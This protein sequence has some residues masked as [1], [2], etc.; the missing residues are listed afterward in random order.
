MQEDLSWKSASGLNLYGSVWRPEKK[1]KAVICLVHG[2]GEHCLRYESYI[3][4]FTKKQIAFV[5]YDQMGHGAS[6]GKRGAISSYNDLLSDVQLCLDKA[7][8]I[9]PD[10]PKFL[11]GHSMGGNIALNFLLK[12]QPEINGA[13][14]TSPWLTLTNNPSFVLRALVSFLKNIFPNLTVN[15]GLEI[16]YISTL[17]DEVEKYKK[18]K[19][20]HGRISFRLFNSVVK[21]GVWAILNSSKLKV[22]TLLM[23]GAKDMITSPFSSQLAAKGNK[24]KIEFIEWPEGFHELHNEINRKE[25]AEEVMNWIDKQH[26]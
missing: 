11:Y 12:R 4:F 13:I 1:T 2:F 14:L 23:H 10:T 24:E 15:S 22:S 8:E 18:D 20:N 16:E 26:R 6:E 25:V 21:N 7:Q 9:F 17:K 19:K 3:D 5:A